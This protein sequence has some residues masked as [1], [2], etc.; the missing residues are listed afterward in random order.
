M[1]SP[2]ERAT[3]DQRG[4]NQGQTISEDQENR[5]QMTN[6]NR[7]QMTSENRDQMTSETPNEETKI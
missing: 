4:R 7:D 5:D 2:L 3:R 6:E 1:R